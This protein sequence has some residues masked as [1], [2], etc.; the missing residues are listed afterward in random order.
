MPQRTQ[1][2]ARA[3]A[4]AFAALALLSLAAIPSPAQDAPGTLTIT[5]G[6]ASTVI[7]GD[8]NFVYEFLESDTPLDA[9]R[10]TACA[11]PSADSSCMKQTKTTKDLL[12]AGPVPGLSAVGLVPYVLPEGAVRAIR[13]H[14]NTGS[15]RDG[16]DG[17]TLKQD[18][19][20]G[21]S[22]S[23]G[24]SVITTQGA[25]LYFEGT[26]QTPRTFLSS[27]AHVYPMRLSLTGS[28]QAGDAPRRFDLRL[29]SRSAP[30]SANERVDEVWFH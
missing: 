8:W 2:A 14:W 5:Y 9:A 21:E 28:I 15:E 16:R 11:G 22:Q 1:M 26:L 4:L 6:N 25:E 24:I 23:L 17:V 30:P 10:V 18:A 27:K 7:V 12:L 29:D 13:I 20:G 19:R 3:C